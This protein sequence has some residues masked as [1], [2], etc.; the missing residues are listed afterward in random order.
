[1]KIH[2]GSMKQQ[3]EIKFGACE[4]YAMSIEIA[5]SL[6]NI[7]ILLPVLIN[8]NVRTSEHTGGMWKLHKI[9]NK[10]KYYGIRWK[11]IDLRQ[12]VHLRHFGRFALCGFIK[13]TVLS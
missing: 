8:R 3:L 12:T 5:S 9:A 13:F 10:V 6:G 2:D 7:T 4:N 1:M 11:F